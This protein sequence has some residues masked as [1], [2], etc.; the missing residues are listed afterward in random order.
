MPGT[1][2]GS[3]DALFPADMA[4]KA[5]QLGVTKAH[6]PLRRLVPLGVLAGAFIALGANF[7]TV[8]TAGTGLDAGVSRALGG[9]VFAL[10]LI[11]VVVGGA[12]LF[13][14]NTLIVMAYASRRVTAT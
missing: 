14:G 10:G 1:A 7:S 6:L 11:L 3:L 13:T 8:V 12:E 5:E 2:N 9:V 4:A